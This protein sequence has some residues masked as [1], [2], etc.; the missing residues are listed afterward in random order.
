LADLCEDRFRSVRLARLGFGF[1]DARSP[2]ADISVVED[3]ADICE[4]IAVALGLVSR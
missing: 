2:S 1:K 4:G 3:S